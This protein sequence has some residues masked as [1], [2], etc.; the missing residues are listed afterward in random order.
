VERVAVEELPPKLRMVPPP[1]MTETP[2]PPP[3][4]E[5][6]AAEPREP[7]TSEVLVA[8]FQGLGYAL[9]ARA[10]LFLAL[11]GAF[12]IGVFA[13]INRDWMSLAILATYAGLTVIPVVWLEI[14][15]RA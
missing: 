4:P 15:K 13:M 14:Q 10:L 5:P 2:S 3:T 11:V 6:V 8:A 1:T 9:S 7:R 12:V